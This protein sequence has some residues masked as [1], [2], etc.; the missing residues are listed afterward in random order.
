[1]HIPWPLPRNFKS[2]DLTCFPYSLLW[3][4]LSYMDGQA[5]KYSTSKS[6]VTFYK[7]I[8]R[9]ILEMIHSFLIILFF[10][11]QSLLYAEEYNPFLIFICD[12]LPYIQWPSQVAQ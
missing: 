3:V 7:S 4:T 11:A 6:V 2:K 5:K 1:M 8:C 9:I 10:I 12:R